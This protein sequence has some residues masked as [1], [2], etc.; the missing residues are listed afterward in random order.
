M[1]SP[2]YAAAPSSRQ[3]GRAN[4]RNAPSTPIA[5]GPSHRARERRTTV[6]A[7]TAA[8][9]AARPTRTGATASTNPSGPLASPPASSAPAPTSAA[10]LTAEVRKKSALERSTI[11]RVDI[12]AL[13][14]NHPP[15]AS[16]PTPP[17]GSS[18]PD[19]VSTQAS[20]RA[21]PAGS[22]SKNSRKITTNPAH[23]PSSSATA[24][25]THHAFRCSICVA[26]LCKGG[27]ASS[28]EV[29]TA[30]ATPTPTRRRM[31][32]AFGVDGFIVHLRP[33]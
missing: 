12:P 7:A 27:T 19:P 6:G 4:A 2:R 33:V 11:W 21:L 15:T 30:I 20:S 24:A 26:T 25:S 13:R 3:L 14:M 22:S 16:A 17:P 8:T 32:R 9:I 31:I 29:N 18:A 28:S 5:T 10:T 1:S 23:D